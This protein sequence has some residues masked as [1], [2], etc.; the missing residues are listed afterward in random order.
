M[1]LMLLTAVVGAVDAVGTV[2][3]EAPDKAMIAATAAELSPFN[4]PASGG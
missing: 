4:S 2:P 1:L 3:L